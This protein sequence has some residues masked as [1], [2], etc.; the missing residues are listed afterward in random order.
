MNLMENGYEDTGET[1][2]IQ[3]MKFR[4]RWL[5]GKFLT[6]WLPTSF[7]GRIFFRGICLNS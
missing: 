6:S 4:V 3:N 7:S 5:K 2:W 1:Y